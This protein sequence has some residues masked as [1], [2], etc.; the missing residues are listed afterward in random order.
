MILPSEGHRHRETA[1]VGE[2]RDA[3]LA[4]RDE[5]SPIAEQRDS[6]RP[7]RRDEIVRVSVHQRF[8]TLREPFFL[9]TLRFAAQKTGFLPPGS[10]FLDGKDGM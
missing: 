3:L 5:P 10:A 4:I 9:S 1:I 6:R 8:R 2:L 7:D